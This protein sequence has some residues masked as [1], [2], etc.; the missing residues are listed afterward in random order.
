MTPHSLYHLYRT[1]TLAT[2]TDMTHFFPNHEFT[3]L[4][5][6]LVPNYKGKD[7]DLVE[8]SFLATN[9]V[10]E[11]FVRHLGEIFVTVLNTI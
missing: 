2:S 7:R 10:N 1:R 4:E 9:C 8:C 5:D 11:K 3:F 6:A